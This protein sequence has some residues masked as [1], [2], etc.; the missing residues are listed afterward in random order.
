MSG[1][2]MWEVQLHGGVRDATAVMPK[3][4][5]VKKKTGNYRSKETIPT[6]LDLPLMTGFGFREFI[7]HACLGHS[8]TSSKSFRGL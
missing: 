8:F 4:T 3:H 6:K 5:F 7:C 2:F 1:N